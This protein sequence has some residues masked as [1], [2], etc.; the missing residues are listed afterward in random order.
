LGVT[1]AVA[2]AGLEVEVAGPAAAALEL[3]LLASDA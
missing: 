3:A 2:A 1:G